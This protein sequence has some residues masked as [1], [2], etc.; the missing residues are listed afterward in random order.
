MDYSKV[1]QN[2]QYDGKDKHPME[3]EA[4]MDYSKSFRNYPSNG[5][6]ESDEDFEEEVK[7]IDSTTGGEY[8]DLEPNSVDNDSDSARPDSE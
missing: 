5:S 4:N 8:I 1:M 6:V 2:E 3:D 7:N